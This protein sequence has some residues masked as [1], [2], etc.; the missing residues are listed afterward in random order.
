MSI[1]TENYRLFDDDGQ[2]PCPACR[3]GNL[4]PITLTEALGCETCRHIFTLDL[5]QQ[6]LKMV[7]REPSITW[8]WTGQHWRGQHL[9]QI[10]IN[11]IYWLLACVLILMPPGLIAVSGLLFPPVSG[12]GWVWFPLVW[13]GI[14]LFA[15]LSM[16]VW[17]VTE[18]YQFPLLLY[19]RTKWQQFWR[20]SH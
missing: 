6:T 15:H 7:D 16:V 17:M 10:E 5:N 3:C 19:V 9:G 4:I 8:R 14:T 12:S 20:V 18:A 11:W 1:L 2:Y 13:A